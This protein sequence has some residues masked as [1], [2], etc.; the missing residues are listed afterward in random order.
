[1]VPV[2]SLLIP[3]A[4]SAVFVFIGQTPNSH[5]LKGLVDLDAGGHAIVDLQM[6]TNVPGLFVAGDVRTKAARQLISAAGDGAT[7]AIAAEHYLAAL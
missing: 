5:L 1:M 6:A 3:I 4:L 7:A 2:L